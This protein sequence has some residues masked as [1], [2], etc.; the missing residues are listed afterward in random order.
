MLLESC[1]CSFQPFWYTFLSEFVIWFAGEY[2]FALPI[3][4]LLNRFAE[5]V[6]DARFAKLLKTVL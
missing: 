2:A 5:N 1:D 6:I 4:W 3:A